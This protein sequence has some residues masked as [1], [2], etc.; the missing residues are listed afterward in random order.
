MREEEEVATPGTPEE[1]RYFLRSL[2]LGFRAWMPA[3]LGMAT[4]LW[5]D[6]RVTRLIGGPFT[7]E[8]VAE[9]LAL[10]IENGETLGLQY[11][12]IFRLEDD[13]FVGCCGFRPHPAAG[14]L[15]LG[16]HLLPEHWGRG[17]AGEAARAAIGHAFAS[18]GAVA[19][20]AGHHPENER[21]A[22][23]LERLGFRRIGEEL[24]PPTGRLHPSYRID[25]ESI[26]R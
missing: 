16:F 20:Y 1:G 9:R 25:R 24:Y 19:V 4:T 21:S 26:A 13:A 3:D 15:E 17:Y 6:V 5:G 22:A 7:N 12:P 2:R 18:L 8:E 14:A 23:L 11:W 10:E